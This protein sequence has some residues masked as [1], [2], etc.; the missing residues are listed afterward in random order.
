MSEKN[1]QNIFRERLAAWLGITFDEL[2]EYG[3]EIETVPND[4]EIEDF[5]YYIEFADT[6]PE[7]ILS[8]ISRVDLQRI[9]YF[10]LEELD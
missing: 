8:K 9:V 4:S 10:N 6:T 1:K 7:S 5:D 3:E 2:E